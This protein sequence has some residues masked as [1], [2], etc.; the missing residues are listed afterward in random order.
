VSTIINEP[1]EDQ[2]SRGAANSSEGKMVVGEVEREKTTFEVALEQQIT[3]LAAEK[4][5]LQ[6][7]MNILLQEQQALK[8]SLDIMCSDNEGFKQLNESL[9]EDII[10][11][12]G[13]AE[14][15][16]T[17]NERLRTYIARRESD[18]KPLHSEDYYI[19][20]FRELNAEI[21]LWI[22]KYAKTTAKPLTDSE[23]KT[24][25]KKLSGLGASGEES[26]KVLSIKNTFQT[27]YEDARSR[28]RLLRH[29]VALFL[30]E[31]ILS[32]FAVG[33]SPEVSNA[34]SSIEGTILS[35]GRLRI[36]CH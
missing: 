6:E 24:L 16:S 10:A 34:L 2:N 35:Q 21:E 3:V 32:P 25:L 12:N 7:Q 15:L 19:Q 9:K 27:L 8:S 29:I 36:H 13:E 31:Q 20:K 33:L 28:I 18:L 4:T 26:S 30:F 14:N 23:E 5:Q 11:L 22:A 1:T 17:D